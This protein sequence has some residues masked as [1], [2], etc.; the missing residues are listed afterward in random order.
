M[1]ETLAPSAVKFEYTQATRLENRTARRQLR[2]EYLMGGAMR[3]VDSQS[4]AC[5]A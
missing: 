5:V 4:T 3:A 2:G 1:D